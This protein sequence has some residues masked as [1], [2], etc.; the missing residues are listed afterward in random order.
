VLSA[1]TNR[2]V[3][4]GPAANQKR[5]PSEPCNEISTEEVTQAL[6]RAHAAWGDPSDALAGARQIGRGGKV[7]SK[8][9]FEGCCAVRPRIHALPGVAEGILDRSSGVRP[10]P[11]P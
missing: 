11:A 6:A 8:D 1:A 7:K 3:A 9:D 4:Q 10:P 2:V 5:R